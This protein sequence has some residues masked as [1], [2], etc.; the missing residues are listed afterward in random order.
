MTSQLY[1]RLQVS[2]SNSSTPMGFQHVTISDQNNPHS[3]S[4]SL[5]NNPVLWHHSVMEA[6][7][8]NPIEAAV[9]PLKTEAI[10]RAEQ[11]ATNEVR[12]MEEAL[13]AVDYCLDVV[14]PRPESTAGRFKYLSM[15]AIRQAYQSITKRDPARV[16]YMPHSPH[17]VLVD[18]KGVAKFV[19]DAKENAAFQYDAFVAKLNRKIGP[20]ISA[21]LE[22]NHVW[23]FSILH[24]VT[25]AGEQRWKTHMILNQSKYGKIFNQFPTRL[26]KGA[27]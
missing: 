10:Q 12:H 20:A 5:D 13:K 16:N 6:N 25:E 24:V 7:T 22:G 26:M 1:I 14:A 18:A 3:P 27:N 17:Y 23:S 8:M 19:A 9:A 2:H 11:Y 4:N 21:Q 15:H